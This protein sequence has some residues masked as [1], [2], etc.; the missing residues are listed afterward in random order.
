MSREI[1]I[2]CAVQ[3]L[4][5]DEDEVCRIFAVLDESSERSIPDGELSLAFLDT[6]TMRVM[7]G[8][9]LGDPVPTDVITFPGDPENDFAGEICI[10]VEYAAECAEE[11]GITLADEMTLYMVHGWLHL[12]G[13]ADQTPEDA[14]KMR[15]E[16]AKAIQL[17]KAQNAIPSFM[18]A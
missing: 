10:S 4:N 14:A 3:R 18:F 9:F 17:L 6:E 8:E 5:Y 11:H 2:Y 7:H 16:E 1:C 13:L 15:Q 12:S